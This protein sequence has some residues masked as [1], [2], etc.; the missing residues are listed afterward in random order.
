MKKIQQILS[1]SLILI[2]LIPWGV[3]AETQ[4]P[5][6]QKPQESASI[7]QAVLSLFRASERRMMTRG[8]EVCLVSPGNSGEQLISGDRLM[9]VWWGEILESTINLY[10]DDQLVWTQTVLANTQTIAYDGESLE[11]G[12]TYDWELVVNDKKYRQTIVLL[13]QA[14]QKAIARDLANLDS[15]LK[16][17]KATAE[18]KAIARAEYFL[19]QELS[20]DALQQ[21]Y[22]VKNPSLN[23]I[24][25]IDDFEN[26]LCK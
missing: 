4:N 12:A 13:E 9:F 15:Q 26:R 24:A 25:Q 19:A 21:L 22:W 17:N 3:R 23:L 16:S 8:D 11:P 18:E 20:S 5:P 10:Q 1:T 6:P 7:L 2:N 14:A